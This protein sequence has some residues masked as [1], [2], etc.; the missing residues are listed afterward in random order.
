MERVDLKHQEK[1]VS[2]AVC[3]SLPD[4]DPVVGSLH[5][6]GGD[7]RVVVCEDCGSVGLCGPGEPMEIRPPRLRPVKSRRLGGPRRRSC[8]A[9]RKE[10]QIL[11]S[12]PRRGTRRREDS[13]KRR[14]SVLDKKQAAEWSARA[15]KDGGEVLVAREFHSK[16]PRVGV[17]FARRL[18]P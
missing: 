7:G 18:L 16:W 17:P 11:L 9:D 13:R 4:L 14:M 15:R 5:R 6:A 1:P 12:P 8:Q 10:P 2:G 3:L